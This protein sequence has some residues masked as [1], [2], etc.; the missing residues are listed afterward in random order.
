[1][2]NKENL[3]AAIRFIDRHFME[4]LTL[5]RISREYGMSKYYFCREFKSVT[6][7]TFKDYHHQRRIREAKNLLRNPGVRVTDVCYEV[8][9]NDISYFNRIFRRLVGTSPSGYQRA[10]QKNSK[11]S[12]IVQVKPKK[13]PIIK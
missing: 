6:G 4:T 5:E 7:R 8:G 12:N 11:K 2:R 10:C 3:Q 9:F 1:M 13:P